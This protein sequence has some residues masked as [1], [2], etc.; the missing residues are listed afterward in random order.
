MTLAPPL[1]TCQTPQSAKHFACVVL[2]VC[3]MTSGVAAAGQS[4]SIRQIDTG[5]WVGPA[6]ESHADFVRLRNLGIKHVLD[7]RTFRHRAISGQLARLRA[8]GIAGQHLPIGFLPDTTTLDRI[9]RQ[10]HRHAAPHVNH[11]GSYKQPLFP[12]YV[13]C[14]L[15][16]DR[17][18]LIVAL[19]RFR[20]Q[21]ID[22]QTSYHQWKRTQPHRRLRGL[23]QAY[24]QYVRCHPPTTASYEPYPTRRH[25]KRR[26]GTPAR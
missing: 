17:I 14:Q 2:I 7:L 15:G 25:P 12:I 11:T 21:G 24:W 1:R 8:M 6:P 3:F 22:A 13:H 10:M 19:Y 26:T 5:V 18:G 23:D 4:S 9:L 20:Y 16:R